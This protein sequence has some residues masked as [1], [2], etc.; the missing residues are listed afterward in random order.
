[1][2]G[3]PAQ[4]DPTCHE[5]GGCCD[6]ATWTVEATPA[7]QAREPRIVARADPDVAELPDGNVTLARPGRCPFLNPASVRGCQIYDTRPDACRRTMIGGVECRESRSR[8]DLI[9]L[10]VGG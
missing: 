5:C 9:P 10:I 4:S 8:L 1:M 3:K 7:D 6:G 2:T